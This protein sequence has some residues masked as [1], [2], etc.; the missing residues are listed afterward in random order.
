MKKWGL[1]LLLCLLLPA[2]AAAV[3]EGV[4][5]QAQE[6]ALDAVFH[7]DSTYLP[8][9]SY[10]GN[11][12]GRLMRRMPSWAESD[13][14][15]AVRSVAIDG[16]FMPELTPGEIR[17]AKKLM[18]QIQE[19]SIGLAGGEE[20]IG[21]K[22][23]VALG[24]YP[25]DPEDYDGEAV[26]VL[27]PGLCL[28]DEQLIALMDAFGR[29]GLA[30]DP[31]GLSARNCMRGGGKMASRPLTEEEKE[32][33]GRLELLLQRGILQ[34]EAANG[35]Y[36]ISLNPEQYLLSD[37]GNGQLH[38]VFMCYPYRSVSDETLL[39][40][41]ITLGTRNLSDEMDLDSLHKQAYDTLTQTL[42]LPTPLVLEAIYS[43]RQFAGKESP[44]L[45]LCFAWTDESVP[46]TAAN[47]RFDQVK[48][49][50]LEV[51]LIGADAAEEII[52]LRDHALQS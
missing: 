9:E 38:D 30:F 47:V 41:A 43:D 40:T 5:E 4:V 17:R 35:R 11:M 51:Q 36:G 22:E 14:H 48:M 23:N 15:V 50:L 1:T 10:T 37:A 26:Y 33:R 3:Q 7:L 21:V 20:I 45:V 24:V 49:K 46:Y 42:A 18:A 39:Y 52:N 31:E 27:L 12:T 29:L 32:R 19:G 44:M 13:V 28:T 34:E 6:V 25:L 2:T 8:D 16:M